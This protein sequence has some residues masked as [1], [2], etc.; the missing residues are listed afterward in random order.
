MVQVSYIR[1]DEE[2]EGIVDEGERDGI[3]KVYQER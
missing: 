3:G 1:K 2:C